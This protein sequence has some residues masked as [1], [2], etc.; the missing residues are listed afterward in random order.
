ME[1]RRN[2]PDLVAPVPFPSPRVHE[3]GVQIQVL[4]D[5]AL[6][7]VK[8]DGTSVD[9][10]APGYT[11]PLGDWRSYPARTNGRVSA[12]MHA[13]LSR[14]GMVCTWTTDWALRC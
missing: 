14:A 12:S 7:F 4:D 8:P 2:P 13:R 1:A 11:Q 9:S 10:I 3:G 5:G 6:R